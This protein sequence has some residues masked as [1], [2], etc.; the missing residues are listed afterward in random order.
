M[1]PAGS[2]DK[3]TSV[4]LRTKPP[5]ADDKTGGKKLLNFLNLTVIDNNLAILF[6]QSTAVRY[7]I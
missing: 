3:K 7:C 5:K 6:H 2:R 4:G 1:F